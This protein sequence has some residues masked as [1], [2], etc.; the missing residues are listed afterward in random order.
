MNKPKVS[1]VVPVYEGMK[2]YEFFLHRCLESIHSQSFEDYEIVMPDTGS[3]A[4]NTNAGIRMAQGEIIKILYQDDYFAHDDALKN[5]VDNFTGQWLVTDCLHDMG[6]GAGY[7]HTV[8]FDSDKLKKGINT[9]GSPSVIAF[10]NNNPLFFDEKLTWVLDC[11]LYYRM[12]MLYGPPVLL[13]DPTV[14]IGIH[15]G[16]ATNTMG[17]DIKREEEI[18]ILKKHDTS[19]RTNI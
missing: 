13:H 12:W 2:N 19:T 6:T 15:D 16:Q 7:L 8:E 1:I 5:I 10:A 4:E 11:D 3:M 9:V 17:D 14:V 18:Y